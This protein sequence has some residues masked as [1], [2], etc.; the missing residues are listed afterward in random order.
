MKAPESTDLCEKCIAFEKS[1]SEEA[2]DACGVTCRCQRQ[3][4]KFGFVG[5]G[6]L[7]IDTETR[8]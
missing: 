8:R 2:F 1:A 4:Q 5:C 3:R 7:Q 6:F